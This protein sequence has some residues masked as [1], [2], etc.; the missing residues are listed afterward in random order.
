MDF[1]FETTQDGV[2]ALY[3]SD[4]LTIIISQENDSQNLR[5]IKFH[6]PIFSRLQIPFTRRTS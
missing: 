2:E 1:G 4:V 5:E 6:H 3:F